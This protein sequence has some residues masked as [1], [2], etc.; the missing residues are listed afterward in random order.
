MSLQSFLIEHGNAVQVLGTAVVVFAIARFAQ[1]AQPTVHSGW[2]CSHYTLA[3]KGLSLLFLLFMTA[4]TI[5]NGSA[6]FDQEWWVA[7]IFLLTAVASYV[8]AYEV[9][10]ASLRW[11]EL[12]VEVR[13]FPFQPQKMKFRDITSARFHST[14]ESVTLSSH[15]GERIWFPYGYRAGASSLFGLIHGRD[16]ESGAVGDTSS[17]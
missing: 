11:N 10:F 6:I 15:G 1:Q 4:A 5:Y 13:R 17:E 9:F 14:T 8:F 16:S 2:T 7:P 12:E 3:V